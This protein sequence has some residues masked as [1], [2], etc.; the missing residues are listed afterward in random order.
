MN[1][2]C[3]SDLRQLLCPLV[4]HRYG[5]NAIT[6]PN[7]WLWIWTL[8]PFWDIIVSDCTS[9]HLKEFKCHFNLISYF[10]CH[11]YQTDNHI[12][13]EPWIIHIW[14][15]SYLQMVLK[16]TKGINASEIAAQSFNFVKVHGGHDIWQWANE[17]IENEDLPTSQH[18][19]HVK[20]SSLLDDPEISMEIW[21]Y[22]RSNKWATNPWKFQEFV[23]K[24]MLPTEADKYVKEIDKEMPK[25]MKCYLKLKLFP[26]IYLKIGKEIS[27][28]LDA[29][30]LISISNIQ[31]GSV[32][33]W[34]WA[35]RW[36]G[37][38][39]KCVLTDYG[40]SLSLMGGIWSWEFQPGSPEGV[41][42]WYKEA[43]A[44]RSWWIHNAG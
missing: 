40:T 35:S 37:R 11:C 21:S 4:C 43:C 9:H 32:F 18:G 31:K 27:L 23:N 14:T 33:W 15:G 25:G 5:G 1:L 17:W 30:Q 41:T 36:G 24:T 20:V 12:T 13:S 3:I 39:T 7:S 22:L 6:E 29:S 2:N 42:S 26:H 8:V 19:H 34:T 16:G 28:Q 10:R 44:S 38:Q